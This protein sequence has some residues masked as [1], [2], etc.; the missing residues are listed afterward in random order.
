[1]GRFGK[2]HPS[3]AKAPIDLN[4]LDVRAEARTLQTA[5][6]QGSGLLS[7]RSPGAQAQKPPPL[8]GVR[9]FEL[10]S[11]CG[12]TTAC[13]RSL[14][15]HSGRWQIPDSVPR[16]RYCVQ[17]QPGNLQAPQAMYSSRCVSSVSVS[18]A[19]MTLCGIF[20]PPSPSDVAGRIYGSI[21]QKES[22]SQPPSLRESRRLVRNA[23][24]RTRLAPSP[25]VPPDPRMSAPVAQAFH[26]NL[27]NTFGS[28]PPDASLR[29]ACSG[30]DARRD[31]MRRP[32]TRQAAG[33]LCLRA[34]RA[35]H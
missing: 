13:S 12:Q 28:V 26:S 19:S 9:A 6:L 20:H 24:E 23:S 29:F 3:G 27:G 15:E 33:C 8:L 30:R 2:V 16:S 31:R 1:V 14:C 25:V 34:K 32:W 11:R 7:K 4:R 21:R 35:P 5:P 10:Q 18:G 17:E 22:V